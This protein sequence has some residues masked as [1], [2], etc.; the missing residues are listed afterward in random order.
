MQTDATEVLCSNVLDCVVPCREHFILFCYIR[1]IYF[2]YPASI[3]YISYI[4]LA[5][6]GT[7]GYISLS[8]KQ[9]DQFTYH[10]IATV[11]QLKLQKTVAR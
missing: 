2:I 3:L 11:N 9:V 4:L 1:F 6:Y 7:A 5:L 10:S 8:N